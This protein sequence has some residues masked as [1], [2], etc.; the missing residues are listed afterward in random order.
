MLDILV[1]PVGGDGMPKPLVAVLCT[2]YRSVCVKLAR[3]RPKIRA[4]NRIIWAGPAE[5]RVVCM[6]VFSWWRQKAKGMMNIMMSPLRDRHYEFLNVWAWI[7]TSVF[8]FFVLC[9]I[10][11]LFAKKKKKN[12]QNGKKPKNLII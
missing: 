3:L 12:K 4:N 2:S 1:D 5:T 6:Y 8:V 7:P 9:P 10:Q 11:N